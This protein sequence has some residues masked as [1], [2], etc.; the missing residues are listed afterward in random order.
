MKKS[1]VLLC[2]M[3][4]SMSNAFAGGILTNTNQSAQFARMLSR[5]ASIDLD[6]VYFNPAGLTQLQN[7]FY[8]GQTEKL[9]KIVAGDSALDNWHLPEDVPKMYF[10]QFVKQ[11]DKTMIA[12]TGSEST[13]WV[14]GGNDHLRDCENYI[15]AGIFH[16]ELDKYLF[17]DDALKSVQEEQLPQSQQN[18]PE[19]RGQ[20]ETNYFEDIQRRYERR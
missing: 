2:G 18:V 15:Q 13:K 14:H 16:L 10:D 7:G 17:D 8:F 9:S 12:R 6:A 11:Y 1:A 3:I 4:L 5:N 19:Q 20:Q